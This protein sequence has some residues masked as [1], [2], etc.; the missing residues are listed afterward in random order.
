[1]VYLV[2]ERFIFQEST[3]HGKLAI[4]KRKA[5]SWR[6]PAQ[7]DIKLITATI[8]A[9]AIFVHTSSEKWPHL[10]YLLYVLFTGI[11][12]NLKFVIYALLIIIIVEIPHL[13]T[14]EPFEIA[15]S[16]SVLLT[17]LIAWYLTKKLKEKKE[18]AEE[19]LQ[20]IKDRAEMYEIDSLDQADILGYSLQ[21]IENFDKE[22]S[23]ILRIIK[24]TLYADGAHIFLISSTVS[25]KF[26][27][28]RYSTDTP[29]LYDTGII[30]RVAHEGIPRLITFDSKRLNPG[31]ASGYEINTLIAVPL[32]EGS[33]VS[34]VLA[35][36]SIRSHAFNER[37]LEIVERFGSLISST[38]TRQRITFHRNR[39]ERIIK[40]LHNE[41]KKLTS[42]IRLEELSNFIIET[43]NCISPLSVAAFILREGNRFE[44]FSKSFPENSKISL[45]IKPNFIAS[46]PFYSL[47]SEEKRFLYIPSVRSTDFSFLPFYAKNAN[48]LLA[49]PLWYEQELSGLILLLSEEQNAYS[50]EQIEVLRVYSNQA[51]IAFQNAKLYREI[52]NMATTDG[53]TGLFNHRKFQEELDRELKR[54]D[55]AGKPLCL[56]LLDIDFF[57]KINDTYGHPAGDAVLKGVAKMIKETVRST[58]IPARYGGEEFAIILIEL[59]SRDAIP[60]AERLRKKVESQIF[61]YKGTKMKATLSIGIAEFSDNHKI[62]KALLIERADKALYHAKHSGRN[63]TVVWD[64]LLETRK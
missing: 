17:G 5:N 8:I 26:L 25:D 60:I 48:S 15:L 36:D 51:S 9:I 47:I 10:L 52:E 43:C 49:V 40:I 19:F 23:E 18:E 1:M 45:Q 6:G 14:A 34:G 46:N 57:K 50:Q 33:S 13:T 44:I 38:L 11:M 3:I 63:R 21:Q 30:Q 55:R 61:L 42:T 20:R 54:H 22:L 29:V 59:P 16:L 37:D 62:S 12:K 4:F 35:I 2:V 7:W 58:D 24:D 28:V 41:T 27:Q 39:Y 56:C 53:L 64:E 31:Y 32:K